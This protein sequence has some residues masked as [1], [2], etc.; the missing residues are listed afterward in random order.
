MNAGLDKKFY[1][2]RV[3]KAGRDGVM[4]SLQYQPRMTTR[5]RLERRK[6]LIEKFN[7][8]VQAVDLDDGSIDLESLSVSGQTIEAFL[9]LNQ[10]EELVLVFS[11]Q[12]IRIDPLVDYQ[13][14]ED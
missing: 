10:I 12:Q 11:Q 4:V 5:S 8:A 7:Q 2:A 3:Q 9:P 1:L 13:V 6:E 14:V